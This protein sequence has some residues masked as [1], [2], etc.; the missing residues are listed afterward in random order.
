MEIEP[1]TFL[2]LVERF[3][4]EPWELVWQAGWATDCITQSLE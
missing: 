3:T 1:M 2:T 4:T